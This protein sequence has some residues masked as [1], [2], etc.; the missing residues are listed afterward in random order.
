VPSGAGDV[1]TGTSTGPDEE[2]RDPEAPGDGDGDVPAGT[3]T[4]PHEEE[5][6]PEVSAARALVEVCASVLANGLRGDARPP[7][8]VIVHV[9]EEVLRDPDAPGCS[10]VEGQGGIS[11][12]VARRLACESPVVPVLFRRNGAVEPA[13]TTRSV[14][15]RM[16]DAL[17]TRDRGCRFPGCSNRRFLHAHH[18]RYWSEGGPTTLANLVCLCS[19]HHALVHEGGWKLELGPSGDLR[20]QMPSGT[21]LPAVGPTTRSAGG[22]LQSANNELG[23]DVGPDTIAV[24]EGAMD[25]HYI[26]ENLQYC[27][28]GPHVY[29][30][31]AGG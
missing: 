20:V 7:V 8:T 9:D 23:I 13:G 29:P 6:E 17:V 25:L 22:G 14:P 2:P 3:S 21:E 30:H 5:D 26:V 12:H 15:A 4:G 1:P 11:G 18:V 10:Y 28:H 27:V 31:A 19:R 16:R 24:G